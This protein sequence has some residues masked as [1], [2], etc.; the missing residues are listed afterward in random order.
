[1][2]A[3]LGDLV[4]A[5]P[6][7]WRELVV[8]IAGFEAQVKGSRLILLKEFLRNTAVEISC[9]GRSIV[10]TDS[11]L[12][13]GGM[14]GPLSYPLLP[15]LLDRSLLAAGAG[16]GVDVPVQRHQELARLDAM[17]PSSA[18]QLAAFDKTAALRLHIL[19]IAD[20]QI[21]PESS[22]ERLRADVKL[23]TTWAT[24]TAQEYHV[25]TPDKTAILLLGRAAD[26]E[27]Y[28]RQPV[29]LAGT[30]V[31]CVTTRKWCGITWDAWLSFIP[32]LAARVGAARAA[33]KPLRALA[34]DKS[35]PVEE[36]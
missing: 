29:E 4:G 11:G 28:S 3:F 20:D 13:E 7:T 22:L 32:F 18:P 6:K 19:L 23:A 34:A 8:V 26:A 31:P 1:M 14:L 21:I 10:T 12:P 9:S 5:F 15:L 35:A 27:T 25:E 24:S 17:C 2:V 36:L 30:I 16:I 33:F